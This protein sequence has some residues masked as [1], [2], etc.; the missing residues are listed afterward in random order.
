MIRK[1]KPYAP[2]TDKISLTKAERSSRYT[3]APAL[4]NVKEQKF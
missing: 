4:D 2:K 1:V 3:A